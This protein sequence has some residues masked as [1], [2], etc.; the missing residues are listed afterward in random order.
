[1]NFFIDLAIVAGDTRPIE[2]EP[3]MF[4]EAWDQPNPESQRK[5]QEAIWKE[6]RDMNKQQV[7]RKMHKSLMLMGF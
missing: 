4:N 5:W 3:Q 6:F 1:M 2:D 7:W